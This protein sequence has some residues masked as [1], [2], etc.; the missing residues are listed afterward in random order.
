MPRLNERLDAL[1]PAPR[2][3][4]LHVLLLP[5]FNRVGAI[6]S[7]WANPKTRTFG[8]LLIDCEDDP[9]PSGG[10]RRDAA[11]GRPIETAA[12][13]AGDRMIEGGRPLVRP[14]AARSKSGYW[15]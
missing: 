4:L 7:C 6:Q 9:K 5:H 2:A 1:G 3:E 12:R 14:S 11:R 8:E 15:R 10:A 13:R